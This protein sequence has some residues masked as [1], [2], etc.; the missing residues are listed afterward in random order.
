VTGHPGGPDGLATV[1]RL[2]RELEPGVVNVGHGRDDACTARA[3]AF[4]DAWTEQGGHLGAIVSW[5]SAAASWLRQADRLATGADTWV[6]ADTPTGWAGIGPRLLDTGRWSPRRTVAFPGVDD[7]TL[8]GRAETHGLRGAT[9][10]GRVWHIDGPWL[11]IGDG[12]VVAAGEPLRDSGRPGE[13][14]PR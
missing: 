14:S 1:L 2:V 4:A 13:R 9:R 11:R 7:P 5:P 6:I 10:D 3:R 12:P 8:A